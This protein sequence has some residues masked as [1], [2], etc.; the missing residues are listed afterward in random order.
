[1]NQYRILLPN[2]RN[3]TKQDVIQFFENHP[4]I[5]TENVQYGR[6]KVYRDLG[7]FGREYPGLIPPTIVK[8]WIILP[9][10]FH[11]SSFILQNFPDHNHSSQFRSS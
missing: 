9:S 7:L 10:P 1:M 2:G 3:S 5:E 6:T 4:L 8:G 11:S